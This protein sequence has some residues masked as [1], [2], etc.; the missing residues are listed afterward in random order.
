M[1]IHTYTLFHAHTE[2]LCFGLPLAP[3]GV[4]PYRGYQ[5]TRLSV[6]YCSMAVCPSSWPQRG[7]RRTRQAVEGIPHLNTLSLYIYIYINTYT[8]NTN[9]HGLEPKVLDIYI[10]IHRNMY[11][12]GL[13]WILLPRIRQAIRPRIVV[14][15]LTWRWRRTAFLDM[16]FCKNFRVI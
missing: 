16:R 11:V 6:M 12:C 10:S 2:G 14:L 9:T 7:A 13:R 8:H 5:H 4:S 3:R 15:E 1:Y